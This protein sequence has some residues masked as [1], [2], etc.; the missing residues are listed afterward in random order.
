MPTQIKAAFA[1]QPVYAHG[2]PA[3][4][5]DRTIMDHCGAVWAMAKSD[6]RVRMMFLLLFLQLTR[7]AALVC[8]IAFLQISRA[9]R[10]A[11]KKVAEFLSI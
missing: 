5:R 4:I 8:R 9:G 6:R 2:A 3:K 7:S 1:E 10:M 11:A